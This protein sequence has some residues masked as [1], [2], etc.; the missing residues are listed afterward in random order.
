VSQS[1]PGLKQTIRWILPLAGLL[2]SASVPAL[3]ETRSGC[4]PQDYADFMARYQKHKSAFSRFVANPV[5]SII[6][7]DLRARIRLGGGVDLDK[8]GS[9]GV[10]VLWSD[11]S[12]RISRSR[13]RTRIRVLDALDDAKDVVS[14]RTEFSAEGMPELAALLSG[15]EAR[16]GQGGTAAHVAPETFATLLLADS[17]SFCRVTGKGPELLGADDV[18]KRLAEGVRKAGTPTAEQEAQ[19]RRLASPPADPDQVACDP[20]KYVSFLEWKR[21]R[22]GGGRWQTYV[23]RAAERAARDGV[24]DLVGVSTLGTGTLGNFALDSAYLGWKHWRAGGK[25]KDRRAVMEA[26]D[27]ARRMAEQDSQASSSAGFNELLRETNQL[28]ARQNPKL[29]PLQADAFATLLLEG[30]PDLCRL[31]HRGFPVLAS[32]DEAMEALD[33]GGSGRQVI[34]FQ[35]QGI[36]PGVL[37]RGSYPGTLSELQALRDRVG[38]RTLITFRND[39]TVFEESVRARQLGMKLI[40]IPLD[41]TKDPSPENIRAVESLLR[42]IELSRNVRDNPERY[43]PGS[44]NPDE[45]I[46]LP[47]YIHCQH[48]KDRTGFVALLYRVLHQKMPADCAIREMYSYGFRRRDPQWGFAK[49]TGL[50]NYVRERF[51]EAQRQASSGENPACPYVKIDAEKLTIDAALE[52]R[53]RSSPVNQQRED[54]NLPEDLPPAAPSRERAPG[55]TRPPT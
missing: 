55:T 46:E 24:K 21:S 51:P 20:E 8:L 31:D 32:S 43:P 53:P 18:E 6:E 37:Y 36:E 1:D 28:R 27:A 34:R 29:P 5:G 42:R 49:N 9:I 33:P 48:G 23:R 14:G 4:D 2:L 13:E 47:A 50:E 16:L 38:I 44:Y 52:G 26:V 40:N 30:A 39:S 15:T 19:A 35:P 22:D 11:V 3:A 25:I 10:S 17:P 45:L 7:N 54:K 12:D 41:G